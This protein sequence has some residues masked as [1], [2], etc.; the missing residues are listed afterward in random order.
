MIIQVHNSYIVTLNLILSQ[1]TSQNSEIRIFFLLNWY[2]KFF[3][4]VFNRVMIFD[5]IYEHRVTRSAIQDGIL[6]TFK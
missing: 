2:E 1:G 5:K 3:L 4:I 6:I